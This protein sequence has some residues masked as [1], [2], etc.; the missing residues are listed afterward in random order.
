MV[1]AVSALDESVNNE[2]AELILNDLLL[3]SAKHV[4]ICQEILDLAER[5]PPTRDVE[6]E[7]RYHENARLK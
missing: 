4:E 1:K 2:A 5:T 6:A 7:R 3:D